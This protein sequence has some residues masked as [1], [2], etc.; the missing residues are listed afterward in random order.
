[1]PTLLRDTLAEIVGPNKVLVFDAL[2][3]ALPGVVQIAVS[4]ETS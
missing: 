1:M 2:R 4:S 3:S